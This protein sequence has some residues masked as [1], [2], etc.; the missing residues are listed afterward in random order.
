MNKRLV[1]AVAGIVPFIWL[2]VGI[3]LWASDRADTVLCLVTKA[4]ESGFAKRCILSKLE[5]CWVAELDYSIP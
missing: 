5:M 1:L 2:L 4:D 3:G